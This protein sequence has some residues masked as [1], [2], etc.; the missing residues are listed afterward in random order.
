MGGCEKA[1]KILCSFSGKVKESLM[2][3]GGSQSFASASIEETQVHAALLP[4]IS[5]Y[6]VEIARGYLID[7][8]PL[9]VMKQGAYSFDELCGAADA[10]DDNNDDAV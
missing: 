10:A 6:T 2:A 4:A 5:D 7:G 1:A 9:G 3:Y 8:F